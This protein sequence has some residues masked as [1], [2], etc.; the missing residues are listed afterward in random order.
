MDSMRRGKEGTEAYELI[1]HAS[2][3]ELGKDK[4]GHNHPLFNFLITL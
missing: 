3:K 2:L 4:M 1:I